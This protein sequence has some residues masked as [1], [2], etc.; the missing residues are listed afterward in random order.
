MPDS[1]V[2]NGLDQFDKELSKYLAIKQKI[3]TAFSVNNETARN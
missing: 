2:D 1:D 3:E